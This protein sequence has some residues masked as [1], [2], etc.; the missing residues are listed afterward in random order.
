MTLLNKF[1][2]AGRKRKAL[3]DKKDEEERRLKAEQENNGKKLWEVGYPKIE[4]Y[5]ARLNKAIGE[6]PFKLVG[7]PCKIKGCDLVL[8]EYKDKFSLEYQ[9]SKGQKFGIEFSADYYKGI[10]A[11]PY[12][13]PLTDPDKWTNAIID[14]F[15]ESI[16]EQVAASGIDPFEY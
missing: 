1:I 9:T 8:A 11:F 16:L 7:K 2:E 14:G 10:T 12:E 3:Q 5:M 13:N 6:N 15:L 4:S